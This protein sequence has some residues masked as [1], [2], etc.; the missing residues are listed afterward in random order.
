MFHTLHRGQR[1]ARLSPYLNNCANLYPLTLPQVWESS[2]LSPFFTPPDHPCPL[3]PL[4]P[5]SPPPSPSPPPIN[6]PLNPPINP[7]TTPSPL[8]LPYKFTPVT[9]TEALPATHVSSL[10][11]FTGPSLVASQYSALLYSAFAEFGSPS[12]RTPRPLL[13]HPP[14]CTPISYPTSNVAATPPVAVPPGPGNPPVPGPC[15]GETLKPP[16]KR[17]TPT[18]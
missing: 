16:N 10:P 11:P 8:P 12:A 5:P 14:R 18:V 6:P 1:D 2:V 4:P 7:P 13:P 17:A 15:K 3:P 9:I